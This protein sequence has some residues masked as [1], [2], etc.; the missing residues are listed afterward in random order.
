M[1]NSIIF[2][3]KRLSSSVGQENIAQWAIILGLEVFL[4]T[5]A[6]EDVTTLELANRDASTERKSA[7]LTCS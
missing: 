4:N 6:M 3:Q 7:Q 1:I 5:V 2:I